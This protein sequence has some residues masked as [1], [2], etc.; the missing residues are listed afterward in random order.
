MIS[1]C[2]ATY[3]GRK[4]LK[5]QLDSI[6]SQLGPDDEVI[7]SDDGSTDGTES[8]IREYEDERIRLYHHEKKP[9]KFVIDY[10]THNFENALKRAK[11]EIIFL[12]DQDD[13]WLPNKVE[14]FKKTLQTSDVVISDCIVTDEHLNKIHA[15]HFR[16]RGGTRF[17]LWND[18]YKSSWL[19]SCMAFRREVLEASL[20]FPLFGVAHDLWIGI[21]SDLYFR[22]AVIEEPCM[23]YRR[24]GDAVTPYGNHTRTSLYFK[25]HYR[26]YIFK[27]ILAELLRKKNNKRE[28][29]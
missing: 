3:N 13:V 16:V 26:Y 20:P 14:L 11:G 9:A 28:K 2:M 25:L 17:G 1:V 22:R 19:G 4:Y 24:H 7:V 15:S 12:A 5:E 18:F 29:A 8:L 6:L 23:L 10:S 27:A 21:I